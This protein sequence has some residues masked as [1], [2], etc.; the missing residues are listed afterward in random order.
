[1][2]LAE[3]NTILN[4]IHA[5]QIEDIHISEGRLVFVEDESW[6]I[7]IGGKWIENLKTS[8]EIE[9]EISPD[10]QEAHISVNHNGQY[11]TGTRKEIEE[12]INGG[13]SLNP[14]GADSITKM[15]NFLSKN[16]SSELLTQGNMNILD[17]KN[18]VRQQIDRFITDQKNRLFSDISVNEMVY[19]AKYN[20]AV[21]FLADTSNPK[22]MDLYPYIQAELTISGDLIDTP[23]EV[24]NFWISKNNEWVAITA[25]LEALRTFTR[26][27][28]MGAA[29]EN[30]IRGY[31][32]SFVSN[33]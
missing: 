13:A 23:E 26:K 6:N 24:A 16:I 27:K 22:N 33:F 2:H 28:V 7:C 15:S 17:Y 21:R 14:N 12:I 5:N 30:E 32:E 31:W 8:T 19:N 11:I 18:L 9:R 3:D 29:D 25:Q 10:F 20:E 1:M 4:V